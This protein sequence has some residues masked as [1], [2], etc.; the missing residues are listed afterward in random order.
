MN[1]WVVALSARKMRAEKCMERV[2]LFA[3]HVLK[4]DAMTDRRYS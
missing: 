2:K 1:D 3:L 4:D